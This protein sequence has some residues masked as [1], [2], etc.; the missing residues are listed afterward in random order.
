[1]TAPVLVAV[2]WPHATGSRH[3]GHLAGANLPAD[4]F[5]RQQRISRNE[6]QMVSGS[7]VH[8]TPITVRAEAEGFASEPWKLVR[9]DVDRVRTVLHTALRAV[10][11]LRVM[12]APYLPFSAAALDKI[13][14][15]TDEWRRP[16][17]E[18]GRPIDK[19]TPLFQ[20]TGVEADAD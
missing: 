4:I 2:T 9:S 10:N 8:G 7:D 3:L 14:G 1:M 19:P 20:K 5:A 11:E 13:L 16:E 6:V 18:V 12:L 15:P 17:L